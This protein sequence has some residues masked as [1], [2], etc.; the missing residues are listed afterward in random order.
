ME[1]SL[2]NNSSL[3]LQSG[4]VKKPKKLNMYQNEAQKANSKYLADSVNTELKRKGLKHKQSLGQDA[5]LKLLV[6]QLKSQD[7]LN[8][9]KDNEFIAQM[10]QFSSLEQMTQMNKQIGSLIQE[11]SN[12]G[13]FNLLGKKITW[14]NRLT[15]RA[16]DGTVES[17][18]KKNG[19]VLL[20]VR[21]TLV[22]PDDVI[23]IEA[24]HTHVPSPIKK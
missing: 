14:I 21:G 22:N 1:S 12:T 6:T 13:S 17:V 20:R 8:P 9:M 18:E 23:R 16:S 3:P 10:A 7:P 19:K 11:A 2:I 5:F 4:N 24:A 15:K